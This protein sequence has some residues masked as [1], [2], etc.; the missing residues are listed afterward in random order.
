MT[1]TTAGGHDGATGAVRLVDLLAGLSLV[2]D[3]SMAQPAEESLRVTLV[4]TRVARHLGLADDR[5][6]DVF[7]TA[8]LQ[9][10]GCT[11]FAHEQ[12]ALL[13]GD[14]RLVNAAGAKTDFADPADVFRTFLPELTRG[15]DVVTR[16]RLITAALVRGREIDRGVAS[17]NC[18]VAAAV[19]DRLGL[20][21]GV[22][23]SLMQVFAWWNGKGEPRGLAG[24][25]IEVAT[26]I[27]QVAA[28]AVL[29]HHLAGPEAALDA[30]RQRGGRTL[31]PDMVDAFAQ[32]G[33]GLL[34]ETDAVD[35]ATAVLE[36]EP[37]PVQLVTRRS[38]EDVARAFADVVDLKSPWMHGHSRQVGDLAQR[39]GERL[40]LPTA[41]SGHLR[42]AGLLHDIGR[43]GVASGVWD[44]P[45]PLTTGER[46]QVMLHAHHGERILSR[47]TTLAPLAAAVGR[48]HERCDGS[49]YHRG[50]TGADL[51]MD[52]RVLGAADVYVALTQDRP[53][54]DAVSPDA[55]ADHLADAARGGAL[56]AE[57]VNAVLDA[58][59][60]SDA[61]VS[62][63]WPAG[64]TDRQI[65]VLRLLTRGCSNREIA[66]RLVVSPRTAEHHVQDIYTRIGVSSRAAAAMF[67]MRHDLVR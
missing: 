41:A 10:V 48:H 15:A 24:S 3:L 50:V 6:A 11:G 2:S 51:P 26:R 44:K 27:T 55:A 47:S 9:H 40:R 13:G 63:T 42:L 58:A 7:Y 18:E 36:C 67:A 49:G 31:D 29:F 65:E 46:E 43:V 34:D 35:T 62:P 23:R 61:R 8:L 33:R 28:V 39:A 38:L 59:G 19:A 20:G 57:A 64:L 66:R 16:V 12:A 56:D 21:D 54:R 25:D 45:G 4:A 32:V 14:D 53:H 37:A 17:A 1:G 5:A 60:Q 22:Q 52:A 30:V